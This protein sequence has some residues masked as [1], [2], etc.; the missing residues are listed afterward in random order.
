MR[1]AGVAAGYAPLVLQGMVAGV[2]V[3]AP[4]STQTCTAP[5]VHSSRTQECTQL[6][7]GHW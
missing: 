4:T 6:R 2:W 3:D 5:Q 1:Q 7:N